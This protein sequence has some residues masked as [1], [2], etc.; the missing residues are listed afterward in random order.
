MEK[1]PKFILEP[2]ERNI[3]EWIMEL[4]PIGMLYIF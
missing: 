4:P 1:K 3:R 2:I